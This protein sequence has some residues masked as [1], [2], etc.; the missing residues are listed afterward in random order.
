MKNGIYAAEN[1]KQLVEMK[2]SEFGKN[3]VVESI[4]GTLTILLKVAE[5]AEQSFEI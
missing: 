5:D 3:S 4:D 2:K 1:I